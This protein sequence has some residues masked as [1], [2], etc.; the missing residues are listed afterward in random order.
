MVQ[1]KG[2]IRG[3]MGVRWR[4]KTYGKYTCIGNQCAFDPAHP[5]PPCHAQMYVTQSNTFNFDLFSIMSRHIKVHT[6]VYTVCEWQFGFY[7]F[8]KMKYVIN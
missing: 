6:H 4:A 8:S 3:K 5:F 7:L 2:C 1:E